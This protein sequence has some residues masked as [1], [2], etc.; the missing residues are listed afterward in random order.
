MLL[1]RDAEGSGKKGAQ[2]PGAE[3]LRDG[4]VASGTLTAEGIFVNQVWRSVTVPNANE[5]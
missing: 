2:F 5:Y 4:G 3:R 1:R